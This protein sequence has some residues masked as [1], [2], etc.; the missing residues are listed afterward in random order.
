MSSHNPAQVASRAFKVG[1]ITWMPT[2]HIVLPDGPFILSVRRRAK[3]CGCSVAN[4][5]FLYHHRYTGNFV[6]AYWYS[7][8]DK[9]M[10]ELEAFPYHPDQMTEGYDIVE[11]MRLLRPRAEALKEIQRQIDEAEAM[12]VR[13]RQEQAEMRKEWVRKLKAHGMEDSAH[14][15]VTGQVPLHLTNDDFKR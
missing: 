13:E 14:Q 9:L 4:D 6:L 8:H 10:M 2:R 11:L 15:V 12:P 7:R 5:L 1:A 3:E